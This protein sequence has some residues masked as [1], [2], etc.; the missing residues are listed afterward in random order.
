MVFNSPFNNILTISWRSILLV[1]ETIHCCVPEM[2]I[3]QYTVLKLVLILIFNFSLWPTAGDQ[4]S[5]NLCRTS[6]MILYTCYIIKLYEKKGDINK[7]YETP[8]NNILTISWRS[9]LLVEETGVPWKNYRPV[10]SHWQILSHNA[11]SSTPRHEPD[12]NSQC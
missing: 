2:N 1:E 12:S 3:W 10:A 11:V 4:M 9:I 5:R 7:L 8:F 6:G